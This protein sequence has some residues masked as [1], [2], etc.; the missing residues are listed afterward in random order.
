MKYK[1]VMKRKGILINMFKSMNSNA[2]DTAFI[3]TIPRAKWLE[4][5][6]TLCMTLK[7]KI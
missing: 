7:N 1:K 4:C 3:N 5:Y 2:K 6:I